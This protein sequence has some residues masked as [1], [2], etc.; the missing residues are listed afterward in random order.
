[1]EGT[2][3]NLCSDLY[4]YEALLPLSS[5]STIGIVRR[6]CLLSLNRHSCRMPMRSLTCSPQCKGSSSICAPTIA[7]SD[8]VLDLSWCV[9]LPSLLLEGAFLIPV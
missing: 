3:Y 2:L 9:I 4:F 6:R 5:S 1:M 7:P 8:R